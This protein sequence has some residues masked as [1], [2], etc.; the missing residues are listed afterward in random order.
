MSCPA[1]AGSGVRSR[2]W[3]GG[4]LRQREFRL[5]W[6]GE[7]VS[8]LGSTMAAVAAPL[9]VISVLRASTFTLSLV[10]AA[11]YVP[12]LIVGLPAGA[13]VDRVDARRLMIGCDL[14]SAL[15][16]AS[17]P[18]AAWLRALTV[19]QV[20][21]AVAL[22]GAAN[23]LFGTA[24]QVFLPTLVTTGELVEGNAKLQ[25]GASAASVGGPGVAG[26]IAAVAGAAALLLNAASFLVSAGCLLAVR[27]RRPGAP[28]RS[29]RPGSPG[30]RS[31]CSSRSP[32]PAGGCCCSRPVPS[33]PSAPSWPALSSSAVSGRPTARLRCLAGSRPRCGSCCTGPVRPAHCWAAALA[34]GWASGPA[35]GSC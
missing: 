22:A 11:F 31:P 35:W 30:C 14:A 33:S 6:A 16:Y 34:A 9:L 3:R 12:W 13:W 29:G 4:L 7:T 20:L 25:A 8:Q 15:L 18:L 24:Y 1:E 5:L 21:L 23:V 26:L 10:T 32:G 17:L 28:A 19:T 2:R 27:G